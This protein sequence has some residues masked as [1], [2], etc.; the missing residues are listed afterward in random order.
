[1]SKS[2]PPLLPPSLHN[3]N[4]SS[5]EVFNRNHNTQLQRR[6]CC[7]ETHSSNRRGALFEGVGGDGLRH[8]T[9]L[10]LLLAWELT[11]A[12]NVSSGTN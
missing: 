4:Q 12:S 8:N 6:M 5:S 1:M 9:G 10:R 7:Y 3:L 11:V 2:A